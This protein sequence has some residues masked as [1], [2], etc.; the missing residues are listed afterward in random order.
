MHG[1]V[2]QI[3]YIVTATFKF[4]IPHTNFEHIGISGKW[5]IDGFGETFKAY[6][7]KTKY[8]KYVR[9]LEKLFD[10]PASN[11][12]ELWE[13]YA[14]IIRIP[15][16]IA[17]PTLAS[18]SPHNGNSLQKTPYFPPTSTFMLNDDK[19]IS[20]NGIDSDPDKVKAKTTLFDK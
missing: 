12:P 4:F 9:D 17:S 2:L 6:S 19:Q 14:D 5:A 20:K 1:T 18:I 15:N 13:S 11:T 10:L 3:K 8:V 7:A 16:S